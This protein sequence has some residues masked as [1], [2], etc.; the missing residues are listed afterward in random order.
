MPEGLRPSLADARNDKPASYDDGCH[1]S[2]ED[3]LSGPCTYGD[4]TSSTTVV[5][6]GDSHAAAWFPAVERL[7]TER[8]WRFLNL[9]KSACSS[10]DMAVWNSTLNRAYSECDQ[11]RESSFRRI[12]KEHP[13]LVLIAN[14]RGFS[15]VGPDG[16]T[17][18]K[19]ADRTAAWRQGMAS[20][21]AR[22]APAAGQVVEIGDTPRSEFDVPVCLSAHQDNALDCAT[23]FD[24]AVSLGWRA[25]ERAAAARGGVGFVDPTPWVCPSGPCP[26]VIGNFM[27][28]RDE[29]HLATPFSSALSRR[30]GDAIGV[31]TATR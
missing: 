16:S 10:V 22:L 1:V 17:I 12:E 15:A 30:L 5:L 26:A 27:V 3:T 2:Q 6:F 23:P 14:S 11:W 8:G 29:H 18:L 28:L 7:A 21:L 4:P 13:A 9:T 20:T 31:V 24:R 25:E 19:G